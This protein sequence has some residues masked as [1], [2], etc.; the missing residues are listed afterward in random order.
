MPKHSPLDL[1]HV[2]E[3]YST[4]QCLIRDTVLEWVKERFLPLIEDHYEA[5]TFPQEVIPELAE[6]GV[7]GATLPEKYNCSDV[8]ATAYG[9]INQSLEYG[10]TGLRSLVSVQSSLVMFPIYRYGSE[11]QREKWLPALAAGKA[12]GCF[13][14]TEP[15]HGSDPGS[16]ITRAQPTA[17]G[18]ILNGAKAWITNGNLADVAV[19][20]AKV[21]DGDS[22]SIRG[23]LV[24]RGMDGFSVAEYKRKLSLRASVTSE[25][26]FKDVFV[27][28]E[29]MLPEVEGLRGPLSC[30]NQARYGIAWGAVGAAQYCLEA[31]LRYAGERHQFGRPIASFQLQQHKLSEMAT[32]VLRM[33]LVCHRLGQLKEDDR[34]TAVQIS[35]A[36]RDN[37]YQARRIARTAREMFGAMGIMLESHVM[38]H[39]QNLESVYT[40]EGTHD[41]H[42]LILGEALTDISAFS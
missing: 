34:A 31:A 36:K 18:F 32:A 21:G 29:S 30:L 7:F 3:L 28:E 4:E 27:P 38:R 41:I 10:D 37:V 25:L 19:V 23:F 16:M 39:S 14:L 12:I 33:Q 1:Y 42:H 6:L 35:L 15:D 24:E 26:F 17:G 9:L 2:D 20:W 22:R 13:G 5:G 11:A 40:Y 8:G